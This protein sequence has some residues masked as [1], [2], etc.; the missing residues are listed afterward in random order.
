VLVHNSCGRDWYKL[1]PDASG[2]YVNGTWSAI[3][4]L[5]KGYA[6]LYFGSAVLPD[7]RLIIEGGEY[8]AATGRCNAVWT[9]QGAIYNPVANTWTSIAPPA[10]GKTSAMPAA[11]ERHLSADQLLHQDTGAVE[12]QDTDVDA[13]RF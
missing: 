10:A 7:G 8:N 6:P 1:T 12:C 4:P 2:S 11:F 3:S 5:P 13:D 9:T